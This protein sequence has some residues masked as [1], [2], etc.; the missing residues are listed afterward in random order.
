MKNQHFDEFWPKENE[1]WQKIWLKNVSYSIQ[2]SHSFCHHSIV[3]I[4][5]FQVDPQITIRSSISAVQS[6]QIRF[7][8]EL[9]R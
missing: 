8:L 2:R 6:I 3:N 9:Q 1:N 4:Q 7:K 5:R